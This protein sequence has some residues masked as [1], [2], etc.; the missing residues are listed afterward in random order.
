MTNSVRAFGGARWLVRVGDATWT[1]DLVT[2]GAV[3]RMAQNALA[4]DGAE[5]RSAA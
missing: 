5:G 1:A 2:T 3:L 4:R